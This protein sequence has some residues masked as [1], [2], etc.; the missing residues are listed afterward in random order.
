MRSALREPCVGPSQGL[1]DGDRVEDRQVA[2]GRWVIEGRPQGHVR[3]AI[4]PDDGEPLVP[5]GSH[6]ADSVAGHR[7]FRGLSMIG[8]VGRLR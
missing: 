5:E 4:V 8:F 7:A 6:Q 2:H 3:A 1:A